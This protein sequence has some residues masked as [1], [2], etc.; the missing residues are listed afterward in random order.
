MKIRK[1]IKIRLIVGSI[2]VLLCAGW[3]YYDASV[4]AKPGK[5]ISVEDFNKLVQFELAFQQSQQTQ[6][7]AL[8]KLEK[9]RKANRER[10][11]QLEEVKPHNIESAGQVM[12]YQGFTFE[13][14]WAN[15]DRGV[16]I[17]DTQTGKFKIM[18]YKDLKEKV[19]IHGK[20]EWLE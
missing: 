12:R 7:E 16:F 11:A 17:L 5:K 13:D 8:E 10:K 4:D 1:P 9:T 2:I 15:L 18:N 14:R 6:L 3:L 20:G 19:K